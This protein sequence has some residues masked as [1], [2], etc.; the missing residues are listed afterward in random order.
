M[1]LFE[2]ILNNLSYVGSV[3]ALIFVFQLS[4]MAF[5]ISENIGIKGEKFDVEKLKA[6]AF[7]TITTLLGIFLLTLGSSL[8]PYVVGLTNIEIPAEYGDIVTVSIIIL[9][10][11][12]CVLSESKK[13]CEHFENVMTH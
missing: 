11:Y 1:D 12:K 3:L 7:R 6:W 9:T 8:I 4:N 2:T 10:S 13:A 5:G